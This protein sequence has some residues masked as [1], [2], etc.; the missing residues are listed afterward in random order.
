MPPKKQLYISVGLLLYI[1]AISYLYFAFGQPLAEIFIPLLVIGV[2]FSGISWLYL[3]SLNEP[4]QRPAFK[5][6]WFLLLL[7]VLW[8]GFYITYGG[9]LINRII[10]ASWIADPATY[11]IIIFIRKLLIFVLIPFIIYRSLGFTLADFG[12]KKAPLKMSTNRLILFLISL[13]V[14]ILLFQYYAG[15]GG[16]EISQHAF[17]LKQFIIGLPLCLLYL[18]FDA[19]LIEEFFFRGLLQARLA[20]LLKSTT[21]GIVIAAII[22]G[23]VHA[24]GLYLR[25]AAS[26]GIEEQLPFLFFSAYS[27]TYM[28]I[29][30]LFLGIIYSKTKNL[31]LVIFLHALVDL[32]PNFSDFMA[33]WKIH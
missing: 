11:S 21:G 24:P 2:G 1:A 17:S 22:F 27:V 14:I 5:N 31:W 3:Q 4:L 19:G 26:E 10:P 16:K 8:I 30:G 25:G 28:S 18:I 9:S 20:A 32:I 12:L 33:T 23:L 13:S 15:R 7:L 29:A 6:E